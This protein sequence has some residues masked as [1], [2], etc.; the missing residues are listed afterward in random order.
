MVKFQRDRVT[1]SRAVSDL[2]PENGEIFSLGGKVFPNPLHCTA[3]HGTGERNPRQPISA[4]ANQRSELREFSTLIGRRWKQTT[5]VSVGQGRPRGKNIMLNKAGHSCCSCRL[6][7]SVDY[8][9][10]AR[11][12]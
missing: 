9:R 2:V 7:S 6:C 1:E 3:L 12:F 8:K 11:I 4:S 5:L 10:I